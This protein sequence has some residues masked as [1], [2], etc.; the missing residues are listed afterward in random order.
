MKILV[1]GSEGQIG[2]PLVIHLMNQGHTVANFDKVNN[3]EQD[4]SKFV[5]LESLIKW[6]TWA[7]KVIFLAFEVGGSKF[8]SKVDKDFQYIQENTLLMAYT[9]RALNRTKTPFLFTSSQMTNMHHTNY[10]FL[11]DLGERYTRSLGGWVCRFWNVFGVETCSEEK[12]HVITDFINQAKAGSIN[13][14]TDGEEMRQ[15]LHVQDCVEAL[16]GWVNDEWDDKDQYYDITSFKWTS[17]KA[18]AKIVANSISTPV[19]VNPG[20][21]GDSLQMGIK[22]EPDTYIHKF[23]KPKLTLKQGIQKVL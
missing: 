15:F 16:E 22:N 23:W 3:S 11:K 8:L 13:M 17:I 20:E 2:K 18:V 9:F 1:L 19:E 10:G 21:G 7:D 6:C 14:R 4:L 12:T 5:N